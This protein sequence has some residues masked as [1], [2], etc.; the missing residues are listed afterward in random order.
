MGPFA[1]MTDAREGLWKWFDERE[2][3]T[4]ESQEVDPRNVINF[5]KARQ[6]RT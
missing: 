2:S 6:R 4:S 5:S 1:A 3:E